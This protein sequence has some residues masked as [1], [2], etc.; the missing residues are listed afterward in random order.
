MDLL[1]VLWET[2]RVELWNLRTRLDSGHGKVMDPAQI[3]T[4]HVGDEYRQIKL[5]Q[6]P[7]DLGQP[8]ARVVALGSENDGCDLLTFSDIVDGQLEQNY[9]MRMPEHSGRLVQSDS[10]VVWQA[11]DGQL[12]IGVYFNFCPGCIIGLNPTASQPG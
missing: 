3:W 5:L 2:G 8:S 6:L 11:I 10:S 1:A 4:G 7:L 9:S 12:F